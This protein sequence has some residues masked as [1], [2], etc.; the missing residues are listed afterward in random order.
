LG[1]ITKKRDGYIRKRLVIGANT[2]LCFAPAQPFGQLHKV[3]ALANKMARIS[4]ALLAR[5]EAFC[6]KAA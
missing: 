2:V 5:N 3:F 4:W 6:A 1:V